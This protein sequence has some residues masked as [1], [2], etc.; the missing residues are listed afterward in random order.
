M[1]TRAMHTLGTEQLCMQ[2]LRS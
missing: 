2:S 1:K